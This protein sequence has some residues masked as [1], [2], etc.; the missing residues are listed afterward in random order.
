MAERGGHAVVL[1]RAGRVHAFVLQEQRFGIHAEFGCE[2]AGVLKQ[3]LALADSDFVFIG[4]KTNQLPEPPYAGKIQGIIAGGP[5]G[6]EVAQLFRKLDGVPVVF[7]VDR[8][9]AIGALEQHLAAVEFAAAFGVDT[10][11]ICF[12]LCAHFSAFFTD[13]LFYY[14]FV[15]HAGNFTGPPDQ[16]RQVGDGGDPVNVIRDFQF[17]VGVGLF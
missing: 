7:D 15:L 8:V 4:T 16:S 12:L 5:A 6:R 3:G 1:E 9:A 14:G 2:S 10:L 13:G 17:F 11:L